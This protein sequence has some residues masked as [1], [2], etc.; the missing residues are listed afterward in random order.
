MFLGVS[1]ILILKQLRA[2][3]NRV[4]DLSGKKTATV[5][6]R[7]TVMVAVLV[8]CFAACWLPVNILNLLKIPGEMK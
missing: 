8:V 2:S 6:K 1:Y 3:E 5:R 4:A 7:V